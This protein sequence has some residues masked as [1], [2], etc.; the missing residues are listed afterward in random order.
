MVFWSQNLRDSLIA[1]PSGPR[2]LSNVAGKAVEI[3]VV[4]DQDEAIC[5]RTGREVQ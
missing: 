2:Y 3:T 5:F 1:S 4:V